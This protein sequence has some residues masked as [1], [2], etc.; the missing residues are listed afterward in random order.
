[1]PKPPFTRLP[2][3]ALLLTALLPLAQAV[4]L[5]PAETAYVGGYTN[6]SVDTRT[7]LMLLDDNTFCLSFMGGSLDMLLGGRWKAEPGA[8]AGVR[9]QQVRQ[10]IALFPAF[11]RPAADQGQ[12]VVFDF[13]GHTLAKARAPVFA[14][15]ADES[16][17]ATL[18]PLFTK[19]KNEW[20]GSYKLPP[21]AAASARYFFMGDVEVDAHGEP[22][23]I[24]VTQ[25]KIGDG[26]AIRVGFNQNQARPLLDVAAL[27]KDD[28][29]QVDGRRFGT[30]KEL[31]QD[32]Q[33]KIR[34]FCIRPAL[35]QDAQ[36]PV[37]SEGSNAQ[38]AAP[39][40][41]GT[42]ARQRETLVPV[43]T[44]YRD[45]AASQGQ[46]LFPDETP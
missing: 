19:G 35:G 28:V 26:K 6:G 45:L 3:L 43:K 24:K 37:E 16:L 34:K 32:V 22:Q 21:M 7:Q 40:Q 44:F 42:A 12:N 23:R 31:P 25:Y 38:E 33:E 14:V 46:P 39:A 30:R 17:P 27:L 11:A 2:K 9:L 10:E 18:Q 41:K 4:A 20:S 1:M 36:R 29:L 5:T 8:D 13:H 15:S